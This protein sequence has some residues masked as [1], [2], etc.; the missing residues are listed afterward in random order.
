[1]E[2]DSPAPKGLCR[3]EEPLRRIGAKGHAS[4]TFYT[5]RV[6][7]HVRL[8]FY[9]YDAKALYGYISTKRGKIPNSVFDG[10]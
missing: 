4:R 10:Q 8:E 3:S 5:C 9:R 6:R 7:E 1:M 2:I